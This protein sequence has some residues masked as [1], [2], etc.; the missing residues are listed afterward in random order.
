[1][2]TRNVDPD[3]EQEVD[4]GRYWSA[5]VAR[6]WLP[7][8]G[9]IVGAIVG[10]LISL[11]GKQVWN[12]SSTVYLGAS[13]SIIGGI[14]PAGPAGESGDGRHDR[15]RGGLDRSRLRRRRGMRARDLHGNVS[16]KSISTGAGTS[17]LRTTANPLVRLTVQAPTR[18]QAQ[19]AANALAQIVVHRLSP[20]ADQK[21]AGLKERIDADQQQIDAIQRQARGASDAD[22]EGGA[23]RSSSVT[24][25]TTSCRRSSC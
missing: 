13:Y 15:A 24:S 14:A 22:L 18:R 1:M 5:I 19:V 6:W 17:T 12:A 10:Y 2:S 3:A 20:F 7:L 16:T 8:L 23:S 25:S 21:I 9:L 11:G 4:L